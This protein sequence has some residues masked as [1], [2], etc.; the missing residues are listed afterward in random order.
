MIAC[1]PKHTL[2]LSF[3]GTMFSSGEN[4]EGALG[5]GDVKSR[6]NLTR[7]FMPVFVSTSGE[8]Y[9]Y[10]YIY[11]YVYIYILIHICIHIYI[12]I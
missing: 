5:V 8:T 2:V 10:M 1:S 9:I 4:S 6:T 7:I 12:Y 3:L 11:I